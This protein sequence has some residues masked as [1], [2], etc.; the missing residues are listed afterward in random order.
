MEYTRHVA[1]TFADLITSGGSVHTTVRICRNAICHA[2]LPAG[3]PCSCE[4]V[5]RV[6]Q[7]PGLFVRSHRDY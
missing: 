3:I 2:P 4:L 6:Q 1:K 7:S 5:K